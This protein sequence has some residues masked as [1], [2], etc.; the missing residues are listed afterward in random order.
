ML[1]REREWRDMQASAIENRYSIRIDA[2]TIE[3]QENKDGYRVVIE[4]FNLYPRISPPLVTVGGVMLEQIKYE[5]N[6]RSINGRLKEKPDNGT[7][8]VNYGFA[9][10]ELATRIP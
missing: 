8:K 3:P 1:K 4:G 6:G 5:P 9:S 7:V 2:A 10:A